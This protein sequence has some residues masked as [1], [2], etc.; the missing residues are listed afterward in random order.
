MYR[1]GR[2]TGGVWRRE[3]VDGDPSQFNVKCRL[4]QYGMRVGMSEQERVIWSGDRYTMYFDGQ[5]LGVEGFRVF[6]H[7]MIEGYVSGSLVWTYRM[8]VEVGSVEA[9]G[10]H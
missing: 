5:L 3:G 10:Q 8:V 6:I 9:K 4:L 7:S 2:S 1:R